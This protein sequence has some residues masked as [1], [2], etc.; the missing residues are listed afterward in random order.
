MTNMTI[1]RYD[2]SVLEA[3]GATG[4]IEPADASWIIYLNADGKPY[5]YWPERD[6]DGA[7]VGDPVRI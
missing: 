3:T 6:A 7:V 2:T 4:Y 1:G 5:L